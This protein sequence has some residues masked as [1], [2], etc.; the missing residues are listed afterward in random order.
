MEALLQL[1][2]AFSGTTQ[3]G[4]EILDPLVDQYNDLAEAART[5]NGF[6]IHYYVD[7]SS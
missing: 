3:A 6:G 2:A 1:A 5:M 7:G 4:F